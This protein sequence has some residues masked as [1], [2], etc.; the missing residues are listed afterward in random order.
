MLFEEA[1]RGLSSVYIGPHSGDHQV[2]NAII[3]FISTI[4]MASHQKQKMMTKIIEGNNEDLDRSK[5][6]A[7]AGLSESF[8]QLSLWATL[9][10][11]HI[12]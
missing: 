1:K 5:H 4:I 3:M 7:A 8:Y 10:L 2:S 9:S 11:P 12:I 6:K